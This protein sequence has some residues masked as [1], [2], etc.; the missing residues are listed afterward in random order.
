MNSRIDDLVKSTSRRIVRSFARRVFESSSC[1]RAGAAAATP[2]IS[3]AMSLMSFPLI[4]D[5][6]FLLEVR[7]L[8]SEVWLGPSAAPREPRAPRALV[9]PEIL[10]RAPFQEL[11]DARA[12]IRHVQEF[13]EIL[14]EDLQRAGDAHREVAVAREIRRKEPAQPPHDLRMDGPVE[15]APVQPAE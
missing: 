6:P 7:S 9:R 15:R 13:Y 12:E 5:A 4:T 11:E 14:E 2:I 8:K 3:K 10:A 1:G